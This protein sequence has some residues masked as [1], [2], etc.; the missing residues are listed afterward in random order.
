MGQGHVLRRH[1]LKMSG[2][3]LRCVQ[4]RI[5]IMCSFDGFPWFAT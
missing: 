4:G 2:C 5:A 3:L 1:A